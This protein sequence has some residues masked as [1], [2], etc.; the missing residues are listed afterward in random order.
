MKRK[1]LIILGSIFV[2]FMIVL[3][4]F[5]LIKG[6]SSKW[7]VALGGII[8]CGLP[9]LLIFKKNIPFNLPSI[10]GFYLFIFCTTYL[11]SIGDFYLRYK[12]WDSSIHFY[13]GIYTACVGITLY[14]L[15]IPEQVR[16]DTSRWIISLFVLS[17]SVLASV[18]WE[19]YEFV[20]DLTVTH[21]M[22]LGGNKDT[23]YD[24][25][26]GFFGGLIIT[27]YAYFRKQEV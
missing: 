4:I 1:I 27:I 15:M 20:G 16:K 14:K 6:E 13:K 5:F 23:M 24:L 2:L 11:G 22:Q 3:F 10:F 7:Q 18:L 17:L 26:C 12:W 8:V 9:I 25:L 21:I 19:I